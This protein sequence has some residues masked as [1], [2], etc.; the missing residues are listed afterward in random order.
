MKNSTKDN[1]Y[2][3]IDRLLERGINLFSF[4]D[5]NR[6]DNELFEY[7]KKYLETNTTAE[8][9]KASEKI[10]ILPGVEVAYG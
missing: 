1:I 2:I 8:G 3:L 10:N 6:F 7:T 9:V 4:T 5:H